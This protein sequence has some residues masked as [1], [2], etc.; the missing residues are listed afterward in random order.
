MRHQL[1]DAGAPKL[2]YMERPE[3]KEAFADSLET[4]IFDG[5]SVRMEF[6]VNRFEPSKP[7]AGPA[8]R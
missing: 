3:I 7:N 6:V 1:S 5:M 8:A 4:V 2:K